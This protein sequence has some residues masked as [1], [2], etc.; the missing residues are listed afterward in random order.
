LASRRRAAVK[1]KKPSGRPR[2][3]LESVAAHPTLDR[4]DYST[5]IAKLQARLGRLTRLA[6]AK[7]LSTV[8]AL[9]GPDAAGKGGAIRRLCGM[10]DAAHYQVYPTP[11]PT[12][13][14]KKRKEKIQINAGYL[15]DSNDANFAGQRVGTAQAI[16]L[17]FVRRAHGRQQNSIPQWDL[18]GQISLIEKWPFGRAPSHEKAWNSRLCAVFHE[19]LGGL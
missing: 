5:Q 17:A 6:A 15:T 11:A 4:K 13:E 3:L 19:F 8:V 14:E 10:I 12:P 7:G 16:N 1:H 18:F 2:G 9:E